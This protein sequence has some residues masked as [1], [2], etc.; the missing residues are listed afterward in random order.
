MK[1]LIVSDIHLRGVFDKRKYLYL[2]RLFSSA[3]RIILNGDFWDGYRTTFDR[4]VS[5]EWNKLFPLLKSKD[6][7]YLY[8]N[9][10]QK[11][12]NDE[13]TSLFSVEQKDRHIFEVDSI[14]YHVEH[15]HLLCPS[16]DVTYHLSRRF[17]TYINIFFQ[18]TEN[19]F[20]HLGSPHN[21]LLK[22][23][24]KTIKKK[25]KKTNFPYWYLCGHTHLA[26]FDEREK[27][28]NSGYIQYGRVTYLIADS[29]GL[30][31]WTDRY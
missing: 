5:S 30:S 10:D 31:L 16:V 6:T 15:G 22:M 3:D 1:T 17:L 4:F 29:S 12:F 21:V 8:G 2:E 24:N 27:F 9:H 23:T 19:I 14:T 28:A 25:L 11:Q 7:I 20:A 13:R 18:F 26:E